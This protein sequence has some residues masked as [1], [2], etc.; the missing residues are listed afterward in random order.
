MPAAAPP[1]PNPAFSPAATPAARFA[2]GAT[3]SKPAAGGPTRDD[4]DDV[5]PTNSTS[6]IVGVVAVGA[7]LLLGLVGVIFAIGFLTPRSPPSITPPGSNDAAVATAAVTNYRIVDMPEADRK[8]IYT[9]MWMTEETTTRAKLP[10]TRD[11]Q[12]G[13]FVRGNLDKI[14]DRSAAMEGA[15]ADVSKADID[16]IVKEGDAKNWSKKSV[17]KA[18]K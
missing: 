4:D 16:E 9:R 11:S 15:M 7:V 1:T 3:P 6:A 13:G 12:I 18:A 17:D 2:G 10:L 14:R 8:R 5:A